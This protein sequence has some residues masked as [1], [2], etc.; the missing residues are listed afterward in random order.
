[1]Q[2]S[3]KK[4]LL[5]HPLASKRYLIDFADSSGGKKVEVFDLLCRYEAHLPI[6]RG[7]YGFV[8]AA[9][10]LHLVDNFNEEKP[11]PP[12]DSEEMTPEEYFDD[13]TLV[14]VKKL[15][16]LF[17]NNQP[18][19]WLCATREVQLMLTLTHPNVMSCTD[20][21]IP[22][23]EVTE[24]TFEKIVH[25]SRSFENVYIVM[26]KMDYTLREVQ[27]ACVLPSDPANEDSEFQ[28]CSLTNMVLHPVSKEYRRH[29]LYQIL[30]GVGYLHHCRVIHRDLKPENIMLD[31]N[32]NTCITDFGQGKKLEN[33]DSFETVLDTCTQ[34]YAAPETLTISATESS[35]IG[36]IDNESF[37]HVDIWSIGCIAAELLIGRPLFLS[38]P[39]GVQQLRSILDVLG[40]PSAAD[41]EAILEYRDEQSRPM[42][43]KEINRWIQQS[44]ASSPSIIDSLL[45]SPLDEELDHNEIKMIKSCLEWDP[46]KRITID[47]AL[48][49]P[50]F[51]SAGYNP[52][53]EG[54]MDVSPDDFVRADD[55]LDAESGRKFLWSLFLRQHPEVGEMWKNLEQ[56]HN[57]ELEKQANNCVYELNELSIK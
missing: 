54:K 25:L 45:A 38:H 13:C 48:S 2:S 5:R 20:F 52:T 44:H 57:Q 22:L 56:K 32:Y 12:E 11:V 21:F 37:H 29:I 3:L 55:I 47:D 14:A 16:R 15:C 1:M 6:A 10:D 42:F 34:W 41:V 27:E 23:C 8:C 49:N 30:S 24:L 17:E 35:H 9:R 7:V 28:R 40:H 36:F 53:T 43:Q 39:G 4:T 31:R 26:K 18:R 51:V 19:L 46:K 33:Q 50:F